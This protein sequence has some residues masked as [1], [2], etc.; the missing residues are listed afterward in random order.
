MRMDLLVKDFTYRPVKDRFIILFEEHFRC[1]YI[2]VRDVAKA[3][4]YGIE[5]HDRM[6]GIPFNVGLFEANLTKRQLCEKMKEHVPDFYI[7]SAEVGEDLA[8]RDYLVSNERIEGLGWMPD[9][10]LNMGIRKLLKGYRI[11]KPNR[12]ANV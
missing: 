3:F 2:H 1:N 5:N 12:F 8:N 7:A 9:H 4:L 6:R 11:L 10:S